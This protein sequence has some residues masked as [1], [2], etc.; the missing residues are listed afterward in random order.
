MDIKWNYKS[1]NDL[2][3]AD[4]E[5]KEDIVAELNYQAKILEQMAI[6]VAEN[7][8][9]RFLELYDCEHQERLIEELANQLENYDYETA[10]IYEKYLNK[11][12][13]LCENE[14]LITLFPT[15]QSICLMFDMGADASD[16]EYENIYQ[17]KRDLISILDQTFNVDE[18]F[19]NID[20][21][22][23]CEN[24]MKDGL[25]A[26][27]YKLNQSNHLDKISAQDLMNK[28]EPNNPQTSNKTS[29]NNNGD[30]QCQ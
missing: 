24:I 28:L 25:E 18:G 29:Q 27:E 21:L 10:S 13:K 14:E 19:E 16:E 17:F 26:I 7:N 15:P 4:F 12:N 23:N 30:G 2:N 3:L 5:T 1:L 6:S 20:D 9:N 11:I 8:S 22:E